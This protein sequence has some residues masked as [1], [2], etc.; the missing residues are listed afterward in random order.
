MYVN[1]SGFDPTLFHDDDGRK[2]FLNMAWNYRTESVGGNP[3]TPAFDGILLQEWDAKEKRLKGPVKN[4]FRGTPLGLVEG[5]HVYKRKGWYYLTT[6][7]GGTSYNHAVTM[8]RSRKLEGPYELHPLS[9]PITSKDH[10]DAPL[11]RRRPRADRRDARRQGLSHAPVR[12]AAAGHAPLAAR[13]RDRDPEVRLARR[14]LALPRAGRRG[15]VRR[16][17]SARQFDPAGR[18]HRVE[19]RFLEGCAICQWSSS[20]CARPTPSASSP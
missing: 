18:A 14:R 7:E 13:A 5:P 10:P 15:A 8:A 17:G 19:A 9:H 4:V 16:G 20:G 11:Q 6:A 12:P 1:S 3:K 2:W